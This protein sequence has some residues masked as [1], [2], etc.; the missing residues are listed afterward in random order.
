MRDVVSMLHRGFPLN[1]SLFDPIEVGG[2]VLSIQA[3]H[4]H[5]CSPRKDLPPY[6]YYEMEIAIYENC[7][8][9]TPP[10]I[11]K[12]LHHKWEPCGRFYSYVTTKELQWIYDTLETESKKLHRGDRV[13]YKSERC[14]QYDGC[15]GSVL[16]IHKPD[17]PIV[18]FDG[19]GFPI[20]ILLV[21]N[22]YQLENDNDSKTS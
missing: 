1:P 8:N 12:T 5:H 15:V 6:L 3:S 11:K 7:K 17:I 18:L 14:K 4:C 16:W 9:T 20:P 2:F 10:I 22:L 13:V 21:E 19:Y